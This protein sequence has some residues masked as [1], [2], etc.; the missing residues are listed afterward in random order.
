VPLGHKCPLVILLDC[1][2]KKC[3]VLLLLICWMF[4]VFHGLI[5]TG[6]FI[7]LCFSWNLECCST[8]S[9]GFLIILL[10]ILYNVFLVFYCHL[11]VIISNQFFV[12]TE[13]FIICQKYFSLLKVSKFSRECLCIISLVPDA[14]IFLI[15]HGILNLCK[16]CCLQ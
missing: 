13:L 15:V 6:L 12:E 10:I 7:A 1:V 2:R 9:S 11:S 8:S 5:K 4:N 14:L 3:W 16:V